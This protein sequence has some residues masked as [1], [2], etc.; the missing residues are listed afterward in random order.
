M[1]PIPLKR[2]YFLS[3]AL[4]PFLLVGCLFYDYG[5]DKTA[6][7]LP[8]RT[9]YFGEKDK[10][11]DFTTVLY[12]IEKEPRGTYNYIDFNVSISHMFKKNTLKR[13][14][15]KIYFRNHVFGIHNR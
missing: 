15:G 4:F 6:T 7:E 9:Y 12:S 3:I 10:K 5:V 2:A 14:Q 1:K 11:Y 8:Y 13:K